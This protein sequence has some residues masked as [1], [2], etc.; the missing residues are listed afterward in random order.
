MVMPESTVR[1]V[2]SDQLFYIVSDCYGLTIDPL[3]FGLKWYATDSD[4]I[5]AT[6]S[7]KLPKLAGPMALFLIHGV[8]QSNWMMGTMG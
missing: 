8:C 1:R 4:C 6:L 7:A 3:G 2:V 5:T